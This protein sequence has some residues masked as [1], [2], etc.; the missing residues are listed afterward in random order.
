[1]VSKEADALRG[2]GPGRGPGD[3]LRARQ[4]RCRLGLGDALQ[5]PKEN[6][7]GALWVF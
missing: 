1:M 5:I 4:S 2:G 6:C 7:A 3:G